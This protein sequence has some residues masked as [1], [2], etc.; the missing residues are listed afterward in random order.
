MK[1]YFVILLTFLIIICCLTSCSGRSIY[2]MEQDARKEALEEKYREGISLAQEKIASLVET[3]LWDLEFDIDDTWGMSAEEAIHILTNYADGE[4][5]SEAE[6]TKAI[7]AISQ[8][9]QGVN[10]IANG[11]DDYWID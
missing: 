4:P 6:V 2:V 3:A 7:W 5:I 11:I 8:Y 9:Y 1:K 10:D